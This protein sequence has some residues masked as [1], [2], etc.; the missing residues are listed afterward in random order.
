VALLLVFIASAVFGS[1][2]LIH[3]RR[4]HGRQAELELLAARLESRNEAVRDH[5]RRLE[6]DDA[7]LEKTVR[8]RLG[9]VRSNEVLY[10]VSPDAP[11]ARPGGQPSN[12]RDTNSS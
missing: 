9:W 6:S 4:L 7:Y 12:S 2:G 10:R 3:L 5:L 11:V 8:E 1:R